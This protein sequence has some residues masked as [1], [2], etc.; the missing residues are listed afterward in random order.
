MSDQEEYEVVMNTAFP[1]RTLPHARAPSGTVS[2]TAAGTLLD[3]DCEEDIDESAP[4]SVPPMS[5][6]HA[7]RLS[8]PITI[9]HFVFFLY[10]PFGIILM[11]WRGFWVIIW[12]LFMFDI[13]KWLNLSHF[14][15]KIYAAGFLM[16]TSVS[17]L[18][19][20]QKNKNGKTPRIIVANH[21]SEFDVVPLKSI[22]GSFS[23]V[24]PEYY[25]RLV[26][27]RRVILELDPLYMDLG[28]KEEVRQRIRAHLEKTKSP[29][30]VFPE[31]CLTSGDTGLMMYHKFLFELEE[32]VLP[33]VL[34][35]HRPMPV[36]VDTLCTPVWHNVLWFALCPWQ[37]WSVE[38]LPVAEAK[39]GEDGKQ[40][41][42]RVQRQTADALG[43]SATSFS[44]KDKK[45]LVTKMTPTLRRRNRIKGM[46][47]Q[48]VPG[49]GNEV[50]ENVDT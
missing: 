41:A 4:K 18:E 33:V 40:F 50:A 27:T 20:L 16:F 31:G 30:L 3:S 42:N 6:F 19:N 39:P 36:H 8:R 21:V 1:E 17:G 37:H 43:I 24:A 14:F 44:K 34:R 47:T 12:E 9:W 26:F 25:K 35:V 45:E 28:G 5:L 38:I 7:T 48:L 32:P 22:F 46:F 23:T 15:F 10:F 2:I 29:L 11:I 13:G 49:R